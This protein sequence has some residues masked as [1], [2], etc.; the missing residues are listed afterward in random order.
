M[1]LLLLSGPHAAVEDTGFAATW[2][3]WM[4]GALCFQ[5]QQ[6]RQQMQKQQQQQK[7]KQMC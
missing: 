6:Q 1:L 5:Q 2:A 7:Q 3:H 4:P